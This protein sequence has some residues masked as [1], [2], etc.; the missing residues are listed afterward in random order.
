MMT[1][2][3]MNNTQLIILLEKDIHHFLPPEVAFSLRQL[4]IENL[5]LAMDAKYIILGKF[6][7]IYL[8]ILVGSNIRVGKLGHW[9]K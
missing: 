4:S 7:H 8:E 6:I 5:V 9:V 2:I 3:N 1:H